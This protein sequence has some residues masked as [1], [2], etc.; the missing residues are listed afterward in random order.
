MTTT[1]RQELELRLAQ[2]DW[3]RA[4]GDRALAE[5]AAY[6]HCRLL[7]ALLGGPP[8]R[9][10]LGGEP[11]GQPP[12]PGDGLEAP[13]GS[14]PLTCGR[15]GASP[16]ILPPV[17][18]VRWVGGRWGAANRLVEQARGRADP[19]REG[20]EGEDEMGLAGLWSVDGQDA[21]LSPWARGLRSLVR[22]AADRAARRLGFA[23]AAATAVVESGATAAG[24]AEWELEAER[25]RTVDSPNPFLPLLEIWEQ[26]YWPL[27]VIEDRFVIF[28]P[29]G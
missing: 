18:H 23:K 11:V 7:L 16:A 1:G 12:A 3:F 5:T 4:G 9:G 15:R 13:G 21:D 14:S 28:D 17:D 2:I 22:E 26:G 8:H 25:A 20:A 10:V 27:G 24:A 6:E 19:G 29:W